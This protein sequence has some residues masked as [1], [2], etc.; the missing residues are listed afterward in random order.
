MF[1]PY[2]EAAA[3][4]A[5][6][7]GKRETVPLNALSWAAASL[8]LSQA[9][10]NNSHHGCESPARSRDPVHIAACSSTIDTEVWC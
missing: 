2:E 4:A 3:L 6:E 5:P 7:A 8:V 10:R 1:L 9:Q